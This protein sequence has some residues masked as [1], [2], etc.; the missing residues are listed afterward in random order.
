MSKRTS[1]ALSLAKKVEILQEV[2]DG[3]LLKTEIARKFGIAKSTV[4]GIVKNRQKIMDAFSGSEFAPKRKRMRTAAHKD[5]ED[6]LLAWIRQARSSNLPVSG[7]VLRAKAEE[8]ALRLHV[9]G[10][11]CSD[12]WLDRFRKRHGLVFRSIV[13]ESA[14]VNDAACTDWRSSRLKDLMEE[15]DAVDIYNVDETALYYQLLPQKTLTFSGDACTGGKH[16]KIRVTVLVGANMTGTDKLKLLV[17][18]KSKSP[19]CFKNVRTLPATYAA[20]SKA[21][22]T[23]ALFEQWLRDMDRC[24]ARQKRNVLFLV[25]NCPGH[26]KVSGL[27]AIRLEFLPPNTTAKL[28]PMDQGV[29]SSLKRHY[30]RSLLQR[31]LLCMENG[32]QYEVNLLSAVHLLSHAWEQVTEATIANS[33]RHAGFVRDSCPPEVFVKEC[34]D[35]ED[36]N[37]CSTLSATLGAPLDLAAYAAVDDNIASCRA[38]TMDDIISEVLD[39]EAASDTEEDCEPTEVDVPQVTCEAADAALQVLSQFFESHEHTEGFLRS[40]GQ[41][42]SFITASQLKQQKQKKITDWFSVPR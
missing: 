3:K 32:K 33:F 7:V 5:L 30:R 41:M 25:D 21:W 38:D 36:N 35:S 27:A 28:Q 6:V 20:N 8:I 2:E 31:M 1:Q 24:F 39:A 22:M 15:Y 16:S 26:G 23:Q 17:I 29:I 11:S 13:G 12:G 40:I 9:E 37:L 10:F 19:R 4:C 14:D 18:G 42:S 34:E